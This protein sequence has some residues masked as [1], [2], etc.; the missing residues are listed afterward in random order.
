VVEFFAFEPE[1]RRYLRWKLRN[2]AHVKDMLQEIVLRLWQQASQPDKPEIRSV[3]AVSRRIAR[4]LVYEHF[5][6]TEPECIDDV[7]DEHLLDETASADR[8]ANAQ[9]NS[10]LLWKAIE[11]LPV[12]FRHALICKLEHN[13]TYKEIARELGVSEKSIGQFVSRAVRRLA[14]SMGAAPRRRAPR[15][16]RAKEGAEE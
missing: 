2:E 13:M 9:S 1:I 6:R 12:R 7:E 15:R 10:A 16:R 11:R 8:P 5:R 4:N 3:A 14:A